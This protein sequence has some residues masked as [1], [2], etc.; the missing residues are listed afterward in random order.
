M[1][2][3]IVSKFFKNPFCWVALTFFIIWFRNKDIVY[4]VLG[5]S[6]LTFFDDDKKN[7]KK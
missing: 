2:V 6:M 5:L 7:S 3:F 4:L 1:E